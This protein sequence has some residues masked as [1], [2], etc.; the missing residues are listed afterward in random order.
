M[1]IYITGMKHC[2]KTTVGRLVADELFLPFIDLD[3][4]ILKTAAENT[5]A[6]PF[7]SC[8]QLFSIF[9][10]EVF[11]DM[12]AKAAERLVL[13]EKHRQAVCALGGG[14]IENSSAYGHLKG[15]GRFVYI[16]ESGDV[17]YERVSSRG[18]PV[19]LDREHPYEDFIRLCSKREKTFA[20]AA[21]IT[22]EA[23]GRTA[24]EIA[25]ETVERIREELYGG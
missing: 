16:R 6:G 19:Y 2:G 5:A 15:T 22:V 20:E 21:D 7:E 25:R 18:L 14:T 17:L 12:E 9:G 8:R 11:R 24:K 1:M 10:R 3:D 13:K 4:I 23:L